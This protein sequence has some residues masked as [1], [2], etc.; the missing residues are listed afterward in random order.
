MDSPAIRCAGNVPDQPLDTFWERCLRAD[1]YTAEVT[2]SHPA[3]RW[4]RFQATEGAIVL[5]LA[6]VVW[7]LGFRGLRRRPD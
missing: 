2:V 7:W 6:G 5:S 1:G 3:S 4:P